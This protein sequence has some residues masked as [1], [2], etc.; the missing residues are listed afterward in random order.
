MLFLL[1]R[2]VHGGGPCQASKSECSPQPKAGMSTEAVGL[3]WRLASS[4]EFRCWSV[5]QV[6][7]LL[8]A[9]PCG[10]A[11]NAGLHGQRQ[12]PGTSTP[13]LINQVD[14]L[15]DAFLTSLFQSKCCGRSWIDIHG[16][17][18]EAINFTKT[19]KDTVYFTIEL[20]GSSD[21]PA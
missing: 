18:S 15:Q 10:V 5:L 9:L 12:L 8:C 3:G 4:Y 13:W 1:L 2:E 16:N 21:V 20:T 14:P 19:R 6:T 7:P 11:T 17:M